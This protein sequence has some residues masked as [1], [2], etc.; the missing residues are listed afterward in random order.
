[1]KINE[2]DVFNIIKST[3][4]YALSI[5]VTSGRSFGQHQSV[6]EGHSREYRD[7]KEFIFGDDIKDIDWKAF[8]RTEKFYV[9]IFEG[10]H[11][12]NI[13]LFV[14]F[15]NSMVF[16]TTK[17]SKLRYACLFALSIAYIASLK[18]E[19]FSMTAYADKLLSYTPLASGKRQFSSVLHQ[20]NGVKCTISTSFYKTLSEIAPKLQKNAISIIFSDVLEDYDFENAIRL[21]RGL[22]HKIYLFNI[23][24]PSEIDPNLKG[25]LLIK[26][27]ESDRS[28][29]LRLSDTVKEEYKKKF[30]IYF[31]KIHDICTTNKVI[32]ERTTTTTPIESHLVKYFYEI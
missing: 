23:L 16:T 28:I 18:N 4:K 5:D 11:T 9:K 24:D 2:R 3:R 27:L 32:Y 15:S 12:L 30:D 22:D 25:D 10:E 6:Y 8:A 14:D 26:D 17:T 19:N 31:K 13:Y 7:R 21:L 1:M 20:I 29:P